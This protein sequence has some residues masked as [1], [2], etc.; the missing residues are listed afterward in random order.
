[1]PRVRIWWI[2]FLHGVIL[3]RVLPKWHASITV[4]IKHTMYLVVSRAG[5]VLFRIITDKPRLANLQIQQSAQETATAYC[6]GQR[7]AP[8]CQT[9]AHISSVCM[10]AATTYVFS[11]IL[12]LG[13][14]AHS[15]D[16]QL[17]INIHET[18]YYWTFT[19]QL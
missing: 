17:L 2:F 10:S 12:L 13:L 16:S 9:N 11:F 18:M 15:S 3:K 7:A 1:M 14:E 5:R 6:T 8:A 19:S 4:S